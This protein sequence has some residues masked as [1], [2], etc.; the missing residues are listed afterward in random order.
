MMF[1]YGSGLASSLFSLRVVGSIKAIA[2]HLNVRQRLA[3]RTAVAPADFTRVL[4]TREQRYGKC[5]YKAEAPIDG[6]YPGTFYLV[7]VDS[8]YRRSYQR[9]PGHYRKSSL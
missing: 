6:L 5:G 2:E 8:K 3:Q 1:S 7:E 9:A 4:D